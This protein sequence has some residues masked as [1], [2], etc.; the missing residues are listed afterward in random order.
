MHII[1]LTLIGYKR[2]LLRNIRKFVIT[3]KEIV[4]LILG[5]NGS[6]KSSV[7]EQL[8][9][10]PADPAAFTKD[11][12][13]VI[14][15]LKQNRH[16]ICSSTFSPSAKHSF[17]MDGEELNVGGTGK[18]QKDLV[19][20][21]F[22]ITSEIHDL[23]RGDE[24]FTLMSPARRREW[25]TMLCDTDYSFA[26]SGYDK[27]RERHRDLSG[28]LKIN[29]TNLVTET[30][31]LMS[32]EDEERLEQQVA[33][34]RRELNILNEERIPIDRTSNQHLSD[35]D[36]SLKT[37]DE[38]SMRLLRNRI[39]VPYEYNDGRQE[40]DEWGQLRKVRFRS[41]SE[42][43]AEIDKLK[44]LVTAK[45]TTLSST[46][47]QYDKQVKHHD[48]LAKAGKDGVAALLVQLDQLATK[49]HELVKTLRL[50]LIFPQPK[51]ALSALDNIL[52]DLVQVLSDLPSNKSRHFGKT[53][54]QTLQEDLI[55][56][57]DQRAE[58]GA[59]IQRLEA[60]KEHA[61]EH[62][63]SNH[64]SCPK[65]SHT[66]TVGINEEQYAK[67]V[68]RLSELRAALDVKTKAQE[69]LQAD[70]R[71]VETYFSQ[72]RNFMSFTKNVGALQPFWTH[73]LESQLVLDS[74]A[75]AIT[76]V[77]L[78]QRDLAISIEI[79]E[80]EAKRDEIRKLK[81][82]AE[83]L[84]DA[85]LSEV[86]DELERLTEVLG[87]LTAEHSKLQRAV[88]DYSEYNRQIKAG[89]ALGE[90]I[91][92]IY[93]LVHEQQY[94]HVEALR[95]E[96]ILH[97]LNQVEQALSMREEALRAAKM[98]KQTVNQ[99][100]AQVQSLQVQEEAAKLM[101]RALSPSHGL[102]AEGLL[103]FIRAFVGQMNGFISKVWAYDMHVIPTGYDS[104]A[105]EQSAEL[106]YKFKLMVDSP[107]NIVPDVSKASDGQTEI[108]NLAFKITAIQYLNLSDAPL[109]LDEPGRTMDDVHRFALAETFKS[110]VDNYNYSQLWLV[111]HHVGTYGAFQSAEFCV[112][113]RNNI[114]LPSNRV[115]NKH[116]VISA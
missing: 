77:R 79:D 31:K 48:I 62:R 36:R 70:I 74:P 113:D 78:L 9:P 40:R 51:V 20:E 84:G 92:R 67:L 10:L 97:C 25:F 5:T 50:G 80:I 104:E 108:V 14:E 72:Y 30:A 21:H 34:L 116:V 59:E 54:L 95:R 73:L 115:I 66:W 112:L 8:S 69:A 89:Q 44:H 12:S 63:G 55:K 52:D 114:A 7:I 58:L 15:I 6:G 64:Q 86:K 13:K 98:K 32:A 38:L 11:G 49:R 39:V 93:E 29:R 42:V 16:Y 94:A 81:E 1:S 33:E 65:C 82:Q 91:K 43:E 4:Q 53:R 37:L 83:E 99:L 60:R 68:A 41:T 75:E 100:E 105:A 46:R 22:G 107:D 102:I 18:V 24:K 45:E 111:S 110:L 17:L 61:D 76:Q 109:F 85:N 56:L 103:G 26:L 27:L 57:V 35:R 90:E 88:M 3:P 71:E 87:N 47:E 23:L 19:R 96:S 2:L 28:A 106:D 101:V